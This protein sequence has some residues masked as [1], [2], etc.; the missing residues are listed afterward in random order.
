MLVSHTLD[1]WLLELAASNRPTG[2]LF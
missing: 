1:M 2:G